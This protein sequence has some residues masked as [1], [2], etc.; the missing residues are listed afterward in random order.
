[1]A[2]PPAQIQDEY[3][4]EKFDHRHKLAGLRIEA[5]KQ[6]ITLAL[7]T[8][9]IP[10]AVAG[11]GKLPHR[12]TV[13]GAIFFLLSL[14]G[15]IAAIVSLLLGVIFLWRAPRWARDNPAA[16]SFA[17]GLLD[18]SYPAAAGSMVFAAMFQLIA[19]FL[20]ISSSAP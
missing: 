10:T 14:I 15:V 2:L 9:A 13:L 16:N 3:S 7:A 6:T 1:M 5:M 12:D 17:E 8:I 18:F 19:A 4:R 20:A 11:I